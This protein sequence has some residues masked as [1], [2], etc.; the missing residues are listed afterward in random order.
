MATQ[1]LKCRDCG[2][3]FFFCDSEWRSFALSGWPPPIRCKSCRREHREATEELKRSSPS[4][5]I[6]TIGEV[7]RRH[8]GGSV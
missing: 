6:T 4:R 1:M 3:D 8:L 7:V 2:K 5:G